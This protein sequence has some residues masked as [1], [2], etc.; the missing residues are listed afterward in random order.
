MK[1]ILLTVLIN[2]FQLA[3]VANA[4]NQAEPTKIGFS[5]TTG[6]LVPILIENENVLGA[7]VY[8]GPSMIIFI[9]ERLSLATGLGFEI[10]PQKA[11]YGG[12][13]TISSD[14]LFESW[15]GMDMALILTH[16]EDRTLKKLLGRTTTFYLSFGLGASFFL[17]NGMV[18]SSM[19]AYNGSLDHLG[20]SVSPMLF[21]CLPLSK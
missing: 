16:D 20:D 6:I 18:I 3:N 12:V 11:N 2:C 13:A 4:Q 1:R 10:M 17:P 15:I 9:S 21:A 19:I 5:L 14:Y 8:I 7:Y